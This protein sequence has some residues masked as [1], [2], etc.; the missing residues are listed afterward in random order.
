[1]NILRDLEELRTENNSLKRSLSTMQDNNGND[2]D[3]EDS[4]ENI[5]KDRNESTLKK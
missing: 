3:D 5:T 2:N 4:K 1:L